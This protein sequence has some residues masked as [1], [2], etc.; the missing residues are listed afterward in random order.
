MRANDKKVAAA[1]T[2]CYSWP[3]SL[4]FIGKIDRCLQVK[5]TKSIISVWLARRKA[6][7]KLL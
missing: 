1:R 7:T 4:V 3:S 6:M 5:E 2:F